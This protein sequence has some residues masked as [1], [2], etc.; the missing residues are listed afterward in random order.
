MNI[1][2]PVLAALLCALPL[3]AI[4][5]EPAAGAIPTLPTLEVRPD[6]GQQAALLAR[7]VVTLAAVQVRPD[8]LTLLQAAGLLPEQLDSWASV[9]IPS[10][11]RLA[12]LAGMPRLSPQA[13][14]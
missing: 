12:P 9:S 10:L 8:A 7:Q 14:N 2:L 6:A 1:R 3:A 13:G 4:A 5:N 11:P